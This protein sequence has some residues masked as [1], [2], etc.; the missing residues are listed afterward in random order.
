MR[1]AVAYHNGG[2]TRDHTHSNTR[3]GGVKRAL[4]LTHTH[5]HTQSLKKRRRERERWW[6]APETTDLEEACYPLV[7]FDYYNPTQKERIHNT[8]LLLVCVSRT[9]S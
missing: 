3:I 7:L 5:T 8:L 2:H 1:I 9:D 4:S 6:C